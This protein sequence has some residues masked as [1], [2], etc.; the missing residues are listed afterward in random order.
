MENFFLKYVYYFSGYSRNK[1]LG[2]E[3]DTA[4]KRNQTSYCKDVSS[5]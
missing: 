4:W 2:G 1:S 3:E 5:I